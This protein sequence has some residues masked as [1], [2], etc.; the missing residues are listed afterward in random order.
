MNRILLVFLILMV[1]VTATAGPRFG[2][3]LGGGTVW[4]SDALDYVG[5]TPSWRLDFNGAATVS[6]ESDGNWS[7]NTGLRY[8]RLGN[9]IELDDS[10]PPSDP[11]AE[12]KA[13]TVTNLHQYVGVPVLFRWDVPGDTVFLI[14]GTELAYLV[15]AES[16]FEFDD[17]SGSPESAE[18]TDEMN[19]FN[20]TLVGGI[21]RA[22]DVGNHF[23]DVAVRYSHG[24][25]KTNENDR[26]LGWK[27]REFA[28][29]V[30]FRF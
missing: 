20:M 24:L 17:G 19:R 5:R 15:K 29:T 18:Y 9:K 8:S 21:G 1:P 25:F 22:F 23:V 4:L 11:T 2:V 6:F 16:E 12:G 10:P 26:S 28:L 14:G 7:L 3:E 27:T 30:G 13:A